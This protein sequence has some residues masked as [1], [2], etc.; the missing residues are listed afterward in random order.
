MPARHLRRPRAA[1]KPGP[2][3]RTRSLMP[4]PAAQAP[5]PPGHL[6]LPHERDE[7]VGEVAT[8]PNPVI[9]QAGHDIARGLVDTDL[10]AT[11]GLDAE[12]RRALLSGA[13]RRVQPAQVLPQAAAGT[14]VAAP[15]QAPGSSPHPTRTESTMS[16]VSEIMTRDVQVVEPQQS[17]QSA[18]QCMRDHDLGALPVCDGERLLGMLTDRD[19][20]VRAVA[21]G[22]APADCCVSDVMSPEI[23]YC[24]VDQDAQEVMDMMGAKQLRRLPVLDGEK[25]LVGI[26]SLGDVA[27]RQ[28]AHTDEALREISPPGSGPM[29]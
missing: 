18:A 3:E 21:D 11:P 16:K 5:P 23:E 13:D 2:T 17:L 14:A 10:R 22:F 28:P 25:R 27:V 26:V 6:P 7:A 20:T 1:P 9:R 12:R 15:V 8:Q 29:A 24:T 19:I 4:P